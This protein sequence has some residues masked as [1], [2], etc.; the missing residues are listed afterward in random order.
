VFGMFLVLLLVLIGGFVCC[1]LL[2]GVWFCR[3]LGLVML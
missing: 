2:L 1:W 3:F